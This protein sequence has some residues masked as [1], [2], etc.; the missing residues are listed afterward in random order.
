MKVAIVAGG[1][2][3][4]ANSLNGIFEFD[5]AMA[6]AQN[7]HDV[8]YFSIDTHSIRHRRNLRM[9]EYWRNGVHVFESHFPLGRVPKWLTISIG[10]IIIKKQFERA[11][12]NDGAPD[13]VHGHFAIPALQASKI[14]REME[15]PLVYTEHCSLVLKGD[16]DYLR[17]LAKVSEEAAETI[18]VSGALASMMNDM[19]GIE[20]TTVYNMVDNIYFDIHRE[21][22]TNCKPFRFVSVG[23][24]IPRKGQGH[25]I[26][27]FASMKHS[28]C[29]L[30]IVGDG[31][32]REELMDAARSC[33]VEDRVF[34]AGQLG[35]E[36]VAAEMACSDCFV[37]SSQRETFGVV[38]A[39]AL[40]SGLPV[41]ATRCGGP[42][43]FI[44]SE[45]GILVDVGDV[46]AL[47]SAMDAMFDETFPSIRLRKKAESEFSSSAI[48][49]Q[50][51]SIYQKAVS[52]G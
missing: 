20:S 41:I 43:D 30:S 35:R 44:S 6:L 37:L 27:A 34:F 4:S 28:D 7:G 13:V 38:Y 32:L 29:V 39:E 48:A 25:L 19:L 46:D 24:L 31:P 45:C 52:H 50:L 5:Q 18:A 1:V 21:A 26:R 15:I 23:S 11:Y 51:S 9:K 16:P 10:S 2:P 22:K 33:G 12:G 17:L 40:A 14:C 3:T 49:S 8:A 42:E 36:G 47:S